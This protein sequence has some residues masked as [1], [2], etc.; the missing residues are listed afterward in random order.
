MDSPTT[1][2]NSETLRRDTLTHTT[3]KQ[4]HSSLPNS[5]TWNFFTT[6]S[7]L[8]RF[9]HITRL[10]LEVDVDSFSSSCTLDRSPP[11]QEWE[12]GPTT[13]GFVVWYST[14]STSFVSTW[15]LLRP[16][17]SL[18]VSD[19]SSLI[20]T[21]PIPSTSLLR[22]SHLGT[23]LSKRFSRAISS[24]PSNRWSMSA[25]TMSTN[26]LKRELS[27]TS[28]LTKDTQL[29]ITWRPVPRACSIPLRDLNRLTSRNC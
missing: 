28:L 11:S 10:S 7:E 1:L 18:S 2:I 16:V 15:P 29:R 26:S 17:T 25:S 9:P 14:T 19:Q 12:D 4:T 5:N 3:L 20:G 24:Q 22:C 27:R 13:N 8:N 21:T 23:M 6:L